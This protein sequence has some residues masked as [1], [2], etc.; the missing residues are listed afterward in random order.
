MAGNVAFNPVVAARTRAAQQILSIPELL[1]AY[2]TEGGL[3]KDLATIR[4][5]GLLAEAL[6]LAQGQAQGSGTGA[7][8][9]LLARFA[10]LQREYAR[11]MAV[12]HA[13]R[14]DLA[15]SAAPEDL[16]AQVDKILVNEA[17]LTVITVTS[18][19]GKETRKKPTRSQAHEALRAEIEKDARALHALDAVHEPL[20]ARKVDSPRLKKLADSAADLA[21]KLSDRVAKKGAAK[22]AT[23]AERDAVAA[24]KKKWSSC[25]RILAGLAATDAR[26]DALLKDAAR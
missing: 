1:A 21:G 15:E 17:A 16:L 9:T 2:Q 18:P 8:A 26:A 12:L 7:T 6:N 22:G 10:E 19:D 3:E 23:Q 24:Q 14:E 20:A 25:Y 11:V 5:Q 13:V 4:D